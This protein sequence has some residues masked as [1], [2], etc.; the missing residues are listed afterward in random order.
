MPIEQE[1]EEVRHKQA[2]SVDGVEYPIKAIET[3][4]ING[5]WQCLV[6]PLPYYTENANVMPAD[7]EVPFVEEKKDFPVESD[8]IAERDRK[9]LKSGKIVTYRCPFCSFEFTRANDCERH[10]NGRP[11]G[12]EAYARGIK[13]PARIRAGTTDISNV[14]PIKMIL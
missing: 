6:R 1:A 7:K 9:R 14:K 5:K 8:L 3:T 2:V 11:S 12:K 13:C 4:I 10:Y